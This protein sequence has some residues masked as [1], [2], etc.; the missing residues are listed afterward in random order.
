MKVYACRRIHIKP[1]CSNARTVICRTITCSCSPVI[2]GLVV[3]AHN[4]RSKRQSLCGVGCI[5]PGSPLYAPQDFLQVLNFWQHRVYPSEVCVVLHELASGHLKPYYYL[6]PNGYSCLHT[7]AGLSCVP[8][9]LDPALA[10]QIGLEEKGHQAECASPP[11]SALREQ[12]GRT[13]QTP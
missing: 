11:R 7:P 4:A 5:S 13:R 8:L 1:L 6:S 3:K 2:Y 10:L 12:G 9:L